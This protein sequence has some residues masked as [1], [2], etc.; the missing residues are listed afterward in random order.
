[1]PSTAATDVQVLF[2]SLMKLVDV[3]ATVPPPPPI[4]EPVSLQAVRDAISGG[5]NLLPRVYRVA[6]A[7]PLEQNLP[8]VFAQLAREED[9]TI[10]EA[11]AGA[12]YQHQDHPGRSALDRFLAVVSNLYRSFLDQ[13]KRLHTDFPLREALPPLT[14][15]QYRAD[16]GP[17]TL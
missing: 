16:A 9:T 12:V 1:M 8:A 13:Q 2:D 3:I 7:D 15:F 4:G 10:L 11:V 5:G 6:Y 14:M 17:F